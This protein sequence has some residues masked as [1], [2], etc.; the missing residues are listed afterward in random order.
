MM[1]KYE[2][3][4]LGVRDDDDDA[5]DQEL[6]HNHDKSYPQELGSSRFYEAL[7]GP[8]VLLNTTAYGHVDMM[9]QTYIDIIQVLVKNLYL[10][11]L[12]FDIA[13]NQLLQ[14]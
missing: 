5:D 9:D 14:N 7:E 1:V 4:E 10:E 6:H 11:M 13:G 12:S 8:T 3:Y 2:N